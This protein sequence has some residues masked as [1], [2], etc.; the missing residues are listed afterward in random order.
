[1]VVVS[2]VINSWMHLFS[3]VW[4]VVVVSSMLLSSV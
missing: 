2:D 1:M 3:R 4:I